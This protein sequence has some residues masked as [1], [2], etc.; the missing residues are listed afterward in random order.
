MRAKALAAPQAKVLWQA[1]QQSRA[2]WEAAGQLWRWMAAVR[3][4]LEVVSQWPKQLELWEC[5]VWR[6]GRC[7][8][9]VAMAALKA[10]ALGRLW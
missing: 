8:N 9:R 5:W 4:A 6:S 10:W 2:L 7:P 3:W 1:V